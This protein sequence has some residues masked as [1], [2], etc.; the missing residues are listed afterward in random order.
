MD[1]PAGKIGIHENI[2]FA[3]QRS[4]HAVNKDHAVGFLYLRAH[5]PDFFGKIYILHVQR[6][7]N[8]ENAVVRDEFFDPRVIRFV[9][10]RT[11][12]GVE[13]RIVYAFQ[14]FQ[15]FRD[16][17]FRIRFENDHRFLS[18]RDAFFQFFGYF[19]IPA[20]CLISR[21]FLRGIF[22]V[23]AV[24]FHHNNTFLS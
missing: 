7:H 23:I 14:S 21:N 10:N 22:I 18:A 24:F 4:P 19:R 6:I 16:V 9:G 15:N 5:F 12:F 11:I 13:R 2:A 1:F 17:Y 8:A 3:H 20:P